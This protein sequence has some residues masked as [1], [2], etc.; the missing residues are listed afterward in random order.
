MNPFDTSIIYFF[1]NFSNQIKTFDYI[2]SF[3]SEDNLIKTT[4]FIFNIWWLWFAK[5]QESQNIYRE[6]IISIIIS[7]FVGIFTV[8][9]LTVVLP[10]RARPMHNPDLNF[11]IPFGMEPRGLEQWSSFPSDHAALFTILA[12]GL[13]FISKR[14]GVVAILYSFFIVLLP[15]IYLG[16]HYPTDIAGGALIG[17][18]TIVIFNQ[19]KF[20]KPISN[21]IFK[22]QNSHQS[23]FYACFFFI[24]FQMAELFNTVR[25]NARFLSTLSKI[26]FKVTHH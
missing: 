16:L 17:I 9:F 25:L 19:D 8:R 5:E 2:I 15:R 23:S 11:L 7:A 3:I 18:L 10:F 1:N 14:L 13:Y 12:F 21:F 4:P 24:T 26:L 22:W 6:K 20:R